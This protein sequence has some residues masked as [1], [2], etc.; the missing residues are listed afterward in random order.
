MQYFCC[1]QITQITP[2]NHG[3]R[4]SDTYAV[5]GA[6][7]EVH[8]CLGPG[9]LEA[10]YQEALALEFVS[11]G[12]T[13]QSQSELRIDYKGTQLT[14]RYRADFIGAA[15]IV[16][17]LKALRKLCSSDEAQVLNYLKASRLSR[18]L[19]LNFGSPSW[20]TAGSSIP[21][22]SHLRN[23]RNLRIT[24][25]GTLTLRHLRLLPPLWFRTY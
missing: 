25:A 19:L 13:F 10:V 3:T 17:E 16:V 12:I 11:R 20:N 18:G 21:I 5:I 23:L 4:D 9:F 22:R 15:G 14:T 1:P 24:S 6:A 7:M 2:M 8:R